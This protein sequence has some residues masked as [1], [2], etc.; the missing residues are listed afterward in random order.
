MVVLD[1]W[2]HIEP[3]FGGVGPAASALASAVGLCNGIRAHQ[4]AICDQF[5]V[6]RADGIDPRV[7]QLANPAVRGWADFKLSKILRHAVAGADVCHVHGLWVP[8]SLAIR[9]LANQLGKPLVSSVHGMLERREMENKRLKKSVYSWLLE[10]PSLARSLCLRALSEREVGD[11]RC[12]GVDRPIALVPNGIRAIER[13]D[14][15]E[16]L[17]TFPQ[18]AGKSVVLFLGRVHPKKGVLNLLQA[19]KSVA[20]CH[21]DAHLVIAG[22]E[23]AG[24]LTRARQIIQD[25]NLQRAVTLMGLISGQTKLAALSAAKYF[26]LP[27][28]SE[29]LSVAVLEAL[30]IGLPAIITPECNIPTVAS[31]GAGIS[32]SNEPEAL[33]QTLRACLSIGSRDWQ[34]MSTAAHRL[35]RTQFDWRVTGKAMHSVYEWLLGGNRPACIVAG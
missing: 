34:A 15:T 19:W 1:V 16:F 3:R 9:R 26:C 8:H 27:S 31:S 10:R 12:F 35:A 22:P 24:T 5:E 17:R 7:E 14:T 21:D 29:G 30:S 2:S 32:T 11:Y 23:Y 13:I 20:R 18:L 6:R 28:Y 33:A 25:L 4:I